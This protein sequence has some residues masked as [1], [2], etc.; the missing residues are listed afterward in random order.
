MRSTIL[1][2]LVLFCVAAP[3]SAQAPAATPAPA[4]AEPAP[5]AAPAAGKADRCR[6][7]GM[8]QKLRGQQLRDYIQVCRLETRLTCL[9]DA[10]AKNV[11]GPARQNYVKSCET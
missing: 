3:A 2:A 11:T 10:I 6:D 7:Q 8:Q 5:S 9:K 4:A 1:V